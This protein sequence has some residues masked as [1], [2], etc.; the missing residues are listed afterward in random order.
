MLPLI[1]VTAFYPAGE[2]T[3]GGLGVLFPRGQGIRALGVLFN[4][5]IFANRGAGHSESWIYGGSSDRDVM[6]LEDEALFDRVQQDRAQLYGR[7]AQA[8]RMHAQRWPRALPHYDLELERLLRRG[9]DTPPDTFLAG[10][11][12]NG[13]GLPMLL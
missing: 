6:H 2:N 3:I 11:Y 1:R 12:L 7:E 4:T 13:I 8:A 9:I 5:N 10:N